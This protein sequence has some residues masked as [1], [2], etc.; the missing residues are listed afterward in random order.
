[1][2]NILYPGQFSCFKVWRSICYTVIPI[3]LV[4]IELL[5]F[6]KFTLVVYFILAYFFISY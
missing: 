4:L 5:L 3:L 6:H 2:I 1:M